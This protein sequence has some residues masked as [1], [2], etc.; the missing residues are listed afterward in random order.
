METKQG[1][2]ED[3]HGL[4]GARENATIEV[5]CDKKRA[6]LASAP[7]MYRALK[8]VMAFEDN[9]LDSELHEEIAYAIAKAEGRA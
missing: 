3:C 4:T 7:M 9:G 2:S 8:K 6:F 1:N 5:C